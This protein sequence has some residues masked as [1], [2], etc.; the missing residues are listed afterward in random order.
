MSAYA[1]EADII[2]VVVL[3]LEDETYR[4]DVTVN[5]SDEGW[6]HYADRWE[7]IGPDNTVLGTRTLFHPHVGEQPFTRSLSGIKIPKGIS[8]VVV[9]AH[10]SIHEYGGR[11]ITVI[12]P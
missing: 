5:H 9:R 2:D 8:Q 12:L 6:D 11:S 10:D 7:I 1:G 3:R 4:F